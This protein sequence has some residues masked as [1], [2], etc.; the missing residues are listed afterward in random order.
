M[1]STGTHIPASSQRC[2]FQPSL[3]VAEPQ[4][5]DEDRSSKSRIESMVQGSWA[6]QDWVYPFEASPKIPVHVGIGCIIHLACDWGA[7]MAALE[8]LPEIPPD[9]HCPHKPA[10]LINM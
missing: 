8:F 2:P 6:E 10:D 9:S 1:S 5:I 7:G 4:R 3:T